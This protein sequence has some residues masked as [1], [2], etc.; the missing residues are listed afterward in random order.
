MVVDAYQ[1]FVNDQLSSGPT[2]LDYQPRSSKSRVS[3]QANQEQKP[4]LVPKPSE[5]KEIRIVTKRRTAIPKCHSIL[6]I[7]DFPPIHRR[8]NLYLSDEQK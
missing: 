2:H 3:T 6:T 5:E 1:L 7:R 8:F 4:L